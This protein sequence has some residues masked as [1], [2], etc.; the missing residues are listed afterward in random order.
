[1]APTAR[2][3]TAEVIVAGLAAWQAAV[4]GLE[5][6]SYILASP[7]AVATYIGANFQ[8]YLTDFGTTAAESILALLLSVAVALLIFVVSSKSVMF[9]AAARSTAS[10]FQSVPILAV[11]P[12]LT[13]WF[14]PEL[15]AKVAASALVC[16]PAVV[17]VLLSELQSIPMEEI[18][19]GRSIFR[20]DRQFYVRFLFPRIT[21]AL[22]AALRIAAPLACLGAIVGEFV[23]SSQGLG[24]RIL[25][26][27]YYLRTSE[28]LA[29]VAGTVAVSLSL[30][31][32]ADILGR[33][34]TFWSGK[35]LQT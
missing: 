25:T 35:R 21:P 23:G 5:V 9:M 12:F 15:G 8:L 4:D 18:W 13:A 7:L 2:R 34:A 16:L 24:F 14:G 19:F 29:G 33:R 3:R 32:F 1:M 27:S 6:P 22:M 30:V 20:N 28:M 26:G 17:N 31:A 10:I 11:A